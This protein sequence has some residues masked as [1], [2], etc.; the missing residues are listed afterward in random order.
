MKVEE[1][2][3]RDVVTVTPGTSLKVVAGLLLELRI[4]GLPVVDADGEVLGVISEG[5]IVAKEQGTA[6]ASPHRLRWLFRGD[7]RGGDRRDARDAGDAM[8]AP[9]I[10]VDPLRSIADAARL[11]TEHG[12]KRLPVVSQGKL[13]GIV[14]RSDLVRAFTRTDAE[15]ELEIRDDVLL[16]SLWIDPT[17][18]RLTVTNGEVTLDGR[19]ETRTQ[20][21][22]LAAY[23]ARVPGVVSVDDS[24]LTWAVDDLSRRSAD[25]AAFWPA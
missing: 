25:P 11:M 15:I 1:L 2:M 22:I 14:T 12:V 17:R 7:E 23:V 16:G 21:E 19:L 4:S 10:T 6:L 9:A 13:V 20:A 3:Q 5:D 18:V 24:L 8:S